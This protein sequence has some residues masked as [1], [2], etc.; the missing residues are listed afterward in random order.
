MTPWNECGAS[1]LDPDYGALTTRIKH[2]QWNGF[3]KAAAPA[4]F[5]P[6]LLGDFLQ[7]GD[8][9]LCSL[10]AQAD[11]QLS[12]RLS[13]CKKGLVSS[14]NRGDAKASSCHL[15]LTSTLCPGG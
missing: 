11:H 5:A 9:D 2:W 13:L 7:L 4:L 3:L 6:S 1:L 10:R 8:S 14:V 15:V 12:A